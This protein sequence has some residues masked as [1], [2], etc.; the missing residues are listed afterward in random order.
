MKII[1]YDRKTKD[2]VDSITTNDKQAIIDFYVDF[3]D[4]TITKEEKKK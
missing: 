1:A 4:C 3:K 2:Y